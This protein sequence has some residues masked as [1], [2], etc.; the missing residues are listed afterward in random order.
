MAGLLTKNFRL[1]MADQFKEQ[2]DEQENSRMFLYI[3]NPIAWPDEANPPEIEDTIQTIS[4]EGWDKM[5]AM[6]RIVAGDSSYGVPRYNW[7]MGEVYTPYSID[8]DYYNGK[9]YVITEDFNVYLCIKNGDNSQS[10]IKPTGTSVTEFTTQDGYKWKFLF[11]ISASDALRFVTQNYIPVKYLTEDDGSTQWQVQQAAKDGSI[12]S[13]EIISGGTNYA[14]YVGSIESATLNSIRLDSSASSVDNIFN[15]YVIYIRSGTGAGQYREIAVYN[16]STRT[17]TLTEPL[18]VAPDVNSNII[19]SPKITPVSNGNSQGFF[20]YAEIV[21]SSITNIV[22]VNGG[23]G[24]KSTTVRVGGNTGDGAILKGNPSPKGGHGANPVRDLYAHNIIMNTKITGTEND[25]FM[26]GNEFRTMGILLD[27]L[28]KDGSPA[29]ASVYNLTT[30]LDVASADN[31]SV[32]EIITGD[33]SGAT[34]YIVNKDDL[35]NMTI[36]PI[37]GDFIEGET[38]RSNITVSVGVINGIIEPDVMKNSGAILY[39][40]NRSPI[41]RA[42]DQQEDIKFVVKL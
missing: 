25:T 39:V 24:Y 1:H 7:T 3:A 5:L 12:D 9:F 17:A 22:V 38:I 19:V 27:P 28:L 36:L 34:A 33:D 40:E 41:T 10:T 31:F 18:N 2:F 42:D 29:V 23:S 6:K 20:A 14:S 30:K 21:S 11:S 32:D 35:S 8:T 13:V 16:G 26:I 37:E 15:G 4:Y